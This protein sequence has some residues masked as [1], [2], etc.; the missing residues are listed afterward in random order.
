[1]AGTMVKRLWGQG[2]TL[3]VPAVLVVILIATAFIRAP[4]Q[5]TYV[6]IAGHVLVAA[7][8]ILAA[9]AITPI[10]IAGRGGVDLS[11]GPL[12]G[13]INVTIVIVLSE[14]LEV[15]HPV[16]IFAWAIFIGC[17]WHALFALIVIYVRV[18]P[19]LVS[20][21]GF[22][23]LQGVNLMILPRPGGW[24]PDWLGDWGFGT[25][26]WG[27]VLQLLIIAVI[28]W[29]IFQRSAI[30]GH[31]RI[32]GADERTAY[33]AGVRTVT[34]RF[35]AHMV[36][37]LFAG[38]AGVAQTGL[39]GSGDPTQ[40]NYLTLQAVTALVLGGTSLAGG[41]GGATG[42]ILGAIA[43]YMVFVVLSTFNFGALTGFITEMT[44]GLILLI[45]LMLTLLI[46]RARRLTAG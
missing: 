14:G 15:T 46:A 31:I 24:A 45:S 12:V 37:G 22:M 11:I 40:G 36:A 42:T 28:L 27:P 19:I 30:F 6:A 20:L 8:L 1:M 32:M 10:A 21:A 16:A 25:E 34:A 18:P 35:T 43:M 39:I 26:L 23:I 9:I 3:L 5:F 7:P 44:Y 33:T 2:A 4:G 17:A 41:R 13:F 38:L 29:A